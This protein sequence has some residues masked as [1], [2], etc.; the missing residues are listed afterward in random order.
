MVEVA[1]M[2]V[3]HEVGLVFVEVFHEGV[4]QDAEVAA[5]TVCEFEKGEVSGG[6]GQFD[7]L[8]ALSGENKGFIGQVNAVVP[9]G[10]FNGAADGY[11]VID[12]T[13]EHPFVFEGKVGSAVVLYLFLRN[14]LQQG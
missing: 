5:A 13:I 8:F 6:E 10:V 9:D 14:F 4:G 3:H 1:G 12:E 11:S 2:E 7:D